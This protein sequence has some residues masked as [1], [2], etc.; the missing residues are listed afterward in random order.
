MSHL[1][2]KHDGYRT[3]YAD[4][5]CGF[6]QVMLEGGSVNVESWDVTGYQRALIAQSHCKKMSWRRGSSR[7]PDFVRPLA[8]PMKIIL[9]NSDFPDFN[10]NQ[11]L[12]FV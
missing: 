5:M 4:A 7:A 2:R 9:V 3:G 12:G 11:F 8:L 10:F 6:I 1:E